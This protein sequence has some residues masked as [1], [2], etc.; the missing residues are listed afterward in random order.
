SGTPSDATKGE[1]ASSAEAPASGPATDAALV[2]GLVPGARGKAGVR[3]RQGKFERLAAAQPKGR[4]SGSP[5]AGAIG[6]AILIP[7]PTTGHHQL[8]AGRVNIATP[9]A[10]FDAPRSLSV[11]STAPR[12]DSDAKTP[13]IARAPAAFA[14]AASAAARL[15]AELM[16]HAEST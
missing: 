14:E 6:A 1:R 9:T 5:D 12:L 15:H 16:A 7:F 2:P 11:R 8:A 4:P 3:A 10:P 13:A